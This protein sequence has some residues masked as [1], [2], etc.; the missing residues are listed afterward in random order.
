MFL[1]IGHQLTLIGE[2]KDF[3]ILFLTLSWE[4]HI[5]L[6]RFKIT[7]LG[8]KT[9]NHLENY[10]NITDRLL[11]EAGFQLVDYKILGNCFCHI[12]HST[13]FR[14][15]VTLNNEAVSCIS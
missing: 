7:M 12:I 14:N 2:R 15:K 5:N 13:H 9:Q 3:N 11:T 1:H 4:Y 6:M 8:S 10:K